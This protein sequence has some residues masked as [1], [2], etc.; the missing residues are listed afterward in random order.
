[1]K[2]KV[3]L[4]Y[5]A[6]AFLIERIVENTNSYCSDENDFYFRDNTGIVMFTAPRER[7]VCIQRVDD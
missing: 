6:D 7:V 4:W 5:P 3:L 2:Y 1:M